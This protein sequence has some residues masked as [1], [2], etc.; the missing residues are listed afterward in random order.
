VAAN[1]E[2]RRKIVGLHIGPSEAETF[3]SSFPKSL[4]KRGLHGVELVISDA[5]EGLKGA[6]A[7]VLRARWQR[8]TVHFAC[9]ALAHVP[10]GTADHGG[11]RT[12]PGVPAA[13]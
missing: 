12:P 2:G 5:H 9:N 7:R 6:I 13:R 1:A 11:R 3:W 10:K 8:C 4:V